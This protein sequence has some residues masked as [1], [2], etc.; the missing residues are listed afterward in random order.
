MSK[1]RVLIIDDEDIV[2]VSCQ[3]ILVPEGYEVRST[4]SAAEGLGLLAQEPVDVVLTDLKMPDIDGMQVLEKIKEEWP[5]IEVI[6]ITGYQTIT[7]AVEAI[8]LG[9]FDYIEKPFT[10]GAIVEAIDKAIS[11]RQ[12]KR[13]D[14]NA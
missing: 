2:R 5:D 14:H 11:H 10:P 9:A 13:Q 1:G 4:N 8:K 3:R 12:E 7:T 6:M